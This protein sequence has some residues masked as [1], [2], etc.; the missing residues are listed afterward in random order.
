M[1]THLGPPTREFDAFEFFLVIAL[2]FG[3]SIAGSLAAALTYSYKPIEFDDAAILSVVVYE[4]PAAVVIAFILRWRRWK[5]SDF[6]IHYSRGATILGVILALAVLGIWL[7]LELATGKG[8]NIP[9]AD[10]LPVLIVS[11]I[12]PVYEEVLVLGYVVQALRKRFG[13]TMAMNVSLAIR[14]T[15]HLYQGPGA[16]IPIAIFGLAMTLVYVR[17]GRLWPAIVAHGIL[18]FAALSGLID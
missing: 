10:L 4:I 13:V 7:V 9:T 12:N 18:D 8:P 15:Y 14:L 5:W 11:I 3:L 2:A 1:E 16:V 17:L 6:A